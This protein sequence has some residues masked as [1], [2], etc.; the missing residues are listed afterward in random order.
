LNIVE[1]RD[2]GFALRAPR[3]DNFGVIA[4]YCAGAATAT[5]PPG[6]LASAVLVDLDDADDTG[7]AGCGF[8]ALAVSLANRS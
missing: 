3:N 8:S 1:S 7:W 5:T 4:R 6:T 2:S